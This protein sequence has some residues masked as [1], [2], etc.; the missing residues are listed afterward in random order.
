VVAIV[1]SEFAGAMPDTLNQELVAFAEWRTVRDA[2]RVAK[3][4]RHYHGRPGLAAE[5]EELL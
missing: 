2:R 1:I 5:V 3:A 4:L